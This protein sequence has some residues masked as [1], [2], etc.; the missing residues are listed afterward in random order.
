MSVQCFMRLAAL[1]AVLLF[2]AVFSL[3]SGMVLAQSAPG[4]GSSAVQNTSPQG[5]ADQT[6]ISQTMAA[7]GGEESSIGEV[8]IFTRVT[9]SGP[10]VFLVLVILVSMSV[11]TWAVAFT[12]WY[13]LR[14]ISDT[15]DRFITIFWDSRSLNDLNSRLAEY[16]YSPAREIFRNGYAELVRGSQLKEQ[17]STNEMAVSAA[18]DN[19]SRALHKSKNQEKRKMEKLLPVLAISASASP[20][21]GLFGTVWGIMN[22]F[23]GIA[24]TGS[25]SLAAVA[26][27][28]S[29]A[30]IATAFGLAAAIPAVI[31]YNI[32]SSKIRGLLS[33]LDGFG[34]DY[35]NIVQRY[36]VSDRTKGHPT[37]GGSNTP[38]I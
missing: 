21:I 26:P 15:S 36:L 19:L 28:I 37:T 10:V 13:Q 16:P 7:E 32:A 11:L 12:K 35:L 2:S 20:F 3:N 29:E 33:T 8:S 27:G 31:G 25:A 34:A 22:S 30:L 24:R 17:A 38:R 18:L 14:K 9:Q 5:G 23:E 1:R 6:A 4:E